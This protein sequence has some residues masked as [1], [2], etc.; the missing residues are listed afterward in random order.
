[1]GS[2]LLGITRLPEV[3]L[4]WGRS[5]RILIVVDTFRST[6][7]VEPTFIIAESGSRDA[8]ETWMAKN[9]LITLIN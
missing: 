7:K 6:F 1:M 9:N 8:D 4:M 5:E 2:N 3:I